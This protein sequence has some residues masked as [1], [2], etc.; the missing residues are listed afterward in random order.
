MDPDP[1]KCSGSGWI[2]IRIRN[3]AFHIPS[4]PPAPPVAKFAREDPDAHGCKWRP[5]LLLIWGSF[6]IWHLAAVLVFPV[7]RS[8]SGFTAGSLVFLQVYVSNPPDQGKIGGLKGN[9]DRIHL[10][11]K[12]LLSK[13]Y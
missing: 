1:A 6:V 11:V 7:F 12:L 2:R 4:I 3:A 13:S 9:A 8:S 10:I 5:I